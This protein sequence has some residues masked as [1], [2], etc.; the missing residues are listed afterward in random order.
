[1]S[2]CYPVINNA[3]LLFIPQTVPLLSYSFKESFG[4]TLMAEIDILSTTDDESYVV[5]NFMPDSGI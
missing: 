5:T 4:E 3:I 2:S 1:M